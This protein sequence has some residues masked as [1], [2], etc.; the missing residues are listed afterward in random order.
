VR[1]TE[2]QHITYFTGSY[3][4]VMNGTVHER[5]TII[6]WFGAANTIGDGGL[7]QLCEVLK[8]NGTLTSLGLERR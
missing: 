5:M 2:H 7:E 1:S 8:T 3:W 4:L 6:Q